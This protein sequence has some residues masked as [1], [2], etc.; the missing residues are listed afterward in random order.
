MSEIHSTDS[1][2]NQK[3]P[4]PFH[5]SSTGSKSSLSSIKSNNSGSKSSLHRHQSSGS[6]QSISSEK[7]D[8]A[9]LGGDYT[10]YEKLEQSYKQLHLDSSSSIK[11]VFES[12]SVDDSNSE[13]QAQNNDNQKNKTKK[14][15]CP[16]NFKRH[17][18]DISTRENS[19]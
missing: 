15:S 5:K 2:Q 3:P 9:F 7:N 4:A 11:T 19:M 16:S 1:I 12:L 8:S 6:R 13:V 17:Q 10:V 18:S 14:S